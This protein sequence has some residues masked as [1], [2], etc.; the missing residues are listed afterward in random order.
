LSGG[1][2]VVTTFDGQSGWSTA[3]GRPPRE[4]HD[5]DIAAARIINRHREDH[6]T[7]KT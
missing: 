1:E 5:A 4:M 2:S 6:G 7:Y 3:P